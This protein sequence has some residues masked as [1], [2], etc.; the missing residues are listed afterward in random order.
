MKDRENTVDIEE[1][2]ES[3]R[4]IKSKPWEAYTS[5]LDFGVG[6]M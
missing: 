4:E 5:V 2:E 3:S 6:S 1:L